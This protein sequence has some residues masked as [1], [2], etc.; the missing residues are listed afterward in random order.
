MGDDRSCSI[1]VRVDGDVERERA[2]GI[3]WESGALG[4]EERSDRELVIYASSSAAAALRSSLVDALGAT[5]RVG[6][7]EPI[8]EVD[9]S[10]QWK[11][12]LAP[13]EISPRLVVAPSFVDFDPAPGQRV[14]RLD[15]GQAFGTGGH[16]STRLVL[17]WLAASMG[18]ETPGGR[19]LDVGTGSGVLALAAVALGA[20]AA[21]GFDL[22]PLAAPE[23]RRWA[24][25]NALADRVRFFTGPIEAVPD[26]PPFDLVLANLLKREVLPIAEPIARRTAAGG[27]LVLSGLLETDGPEVLAAFAAFGLAEVDRRLCVDDNGD[28]WLSPCLARR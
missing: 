28:R 7:A 9:W 12:G 3:A 22:D 1:L 5:A 8:E 16:A 24:R 19:V 21:L 26:E 18:N 20:D 17:E 13:I 6:P 11:V 14:L 23:A 25:V 27:R 15:P 10:E 2:V 4:A